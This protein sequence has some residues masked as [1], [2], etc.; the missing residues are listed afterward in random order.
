MFS[1]IQEKLITDL[2]YCE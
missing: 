1:E 2:V